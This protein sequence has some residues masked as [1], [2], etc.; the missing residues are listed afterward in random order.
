MSIKFLLLGGGSGFFQRGGGGSANFIF[1][2]VG[3][4][5][6]FGA[7]FICCGFFLASIF[8]K[9]NVQTG[10]LHR[11]LVRRFL[12]FSRRFS[13]CFLC[14]FLVCRF[15]RE[16]SAVFSSTLWRFKNRCS[17]VTL[18][19]RRKSAEKSAASQLPCSGGGPHSI[20][21]ADSTSR[22]RR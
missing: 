5:P 6:N 17:R 8:Q 2:G 21:R 1:M 19:M 3:I 16:F 13:C 14:R 7:D 20:F 18:K 22:N 15:L 11:F 12:P 10:F 9:R 4:F